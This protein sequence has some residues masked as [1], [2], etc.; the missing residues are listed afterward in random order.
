MGGP[1]DLLVLYGQ[2]GLKMPSI[3]TKT[4]F[5][6]KKIHNHVCFVVKGGLRDRD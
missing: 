2:L 5:P 1:L 3:N 4:Y 6:E